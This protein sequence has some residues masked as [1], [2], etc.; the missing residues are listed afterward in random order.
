MK[1]R[2]IALIAIVYFSLPS[3]VI[4]K[5]KKTKTVFTKV[6]AK[7]TIFDTFSYPVRVVPK[8][9]A[10]ILSESQGVVIKIKSRLGEKVKKGTVLAVIK[11]QDPVY[12]YRPVKV[13]SP[14][15]GI[16]SRVHIT[17]GSLVP[18]GQ[19]LLTVTDPN[20]MQVLFEVTSMDLN[21]IDEGLPGTMKLKGNPKEYRVR[22]RGVSPF[23]NP[24]TGTA[25]AEVEFVTEENLPKLLGALGRV[26]FKSNIHAGYIVKDDALVYQ[27]R[28]T[29]LRK[30]VDSK[31]KRFKVDLGEKR[32]G[33]V[34]ILKGITKGD[35]VIV[36]SS[37]FLIDGEKVEVK[38]TD[39]K[40]EN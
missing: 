1:L 31:V 29:F 21:A 13:K 24:A 11:H 16:I 20:K 33:E 18:K 37:G 22:V 7:S 10:S 26:S 8:I 36:R 40:K 17:E 4:A 23:V 14:I 3:I 15:N 38:N 28:E 19:K 2:P 9:N 25:E 32:R 39:K 5:S 27:G 35:E 30:I 12:K 34:E 6:M